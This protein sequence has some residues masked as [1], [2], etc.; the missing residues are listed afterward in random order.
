MPIS[1]PFCYMN[2]GII[3]VVFLGYMERCT[4]EYHVFRCPL[5]IFPVRQRYLF[6]YI[7]VNELHIERLG[8]LLLKR[9]YLF[10]YQYYV[11]RGLL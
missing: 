7:V 10:S 6:V 2:F 9:S 11:I 5:G 4:T 3:S 8:V 1:I